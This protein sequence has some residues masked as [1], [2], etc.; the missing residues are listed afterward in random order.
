M[1]A[2]ARLAV[3]GG[4]LLALGGLFLLWHLGP[5]VPY[6]LGLRSVRLAALLLVGAAVGAATVLFQAAVRNQILTPGILGFDALFVVLQIGLILVLG[7]TGRAAL[8]EAALMLDEAALM[9]AAACLLFGALLTRGPRD[10]TRM[11]LVGVIL[12]GLLRS[13]AGLAG[14]LLDP[15]E[16]AVVQAVTFATFGPVSGT[17]LLLATI[18]VLPALVLAQRMAPTLDVLALGRDRAVA[19][20]LPHDRVVLQVLVLTAMLTA[21]TTALVGPVTFM[22]LLA[23]SLARAALGTHRHALLLPG[24]AVV[25]ALCLVAG[26]TAF[27]R[28]LGL[29]SSLAIVIEF[30][31]GLLFLLLVMRSR[32]R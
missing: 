16:F 11:L 32:T 23:A 26:Q 15:S 8:P 10:L 30:A 22:G 20:G 24:A 2:E 14:R 21:A 1:R 27:E 12:G 5:P 31:G 19:L 25:G 7:A 18:L 3:L 13:L 28:L 6:I 29:Q 9:V 4:T 17:A